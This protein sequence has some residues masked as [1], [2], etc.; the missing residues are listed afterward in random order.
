MVRQQ[1]GTA[2][3]CGCAPLCARAHP[4]CACCRWWPLLGLA[5]LSE[6]ALPSMAPASWRHCAWW[7]LVAAASW[8]RHTLA[9]WSSLCSGGLLGALVC[10]VTRSQLA[11]TLTASAPMP[12][13]GCG[14]MPPSML[15]TGWDG[16]AWV[17]AAPQ[18]PH[19]GM[20]RRLLPRAAAATMRPRQLRH[21]STSRQQ[22][23]RP[24]GAA[25]FSTNRP[26]PATRQ[27]CVRPPPARRT[28]QHRQLQQQHRRR[29]QLLLCARSCC[30]Y[31]QG[32]ARPAARRRRRGCQSGTSQRR[33][34]SAPDARACARQRRVWA[35]DNGSSGA[36]AQPAAAGTK[37]P[38]LPAR[39]QHATQ[40][41]STSSSEWQCGSQ[42]AQQCCKRRCVK[43]QA[44]QRQRL[45]VPQARRHCC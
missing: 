25:C 38:Q 39:A 13:G 17:L 29:Q 22:P 10:R 42:S 2:A 44:E 4:V 8:C 6:A 26:Q 19:P 40:P 45:R 35:L 16:W 18:T 43:Q 27:C 1:A 23:W 20:Q 34:R 5:R 21:P 31:T 41:G 28:H 3:S 12:A 7:P 14:R 37:T 9:A 24:A 36:R 32:C 33:P 15:P 11:G 30:C